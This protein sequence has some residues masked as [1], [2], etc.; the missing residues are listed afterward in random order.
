MKLYEKMDKGVYMIAEMSANHG[1]NLENALKIVEEAKKAGADCV[2]IQTYT[3]DTITIDCDNDYFKIKGGLWDGYSYYDL[4]KQAYTPWEWHEPIKRKCEETGIDFLSTP[5]DMSSVDFLDEL[6]VEAYKIASFELV[7]IPLIEYAAGKGKPMIISCGM[8]GIDEIEEA[9]NACKRNNNEQII[10]LKCCS[11]YPAQFEDMNVAVIEDMRKRFHTYIGLSDHSQGYLAAVV[12]VSLGAKIIEK[13]VCLS[14]EIESA[15][16]EFSMEMKEYSQL[17]EAVRNAS[18]IKGE[19][20][21]ELTKNEKAGLASRRSLF[22]VKDIKKGETF[23]RENV[24][25]I[26]PGYGLKPKYYDMIIGKRAVL[27]YKYGQPISDVE[28]DTL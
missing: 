14:R 17:V 6:G 28:I 15:D 27:E 8:A 18:I 13:H 11:Q 2:K 4:Y 10:L 23:T 16:R 19:A 20:V 21:Y 22:A 25:S 5:F 9:V 1:G 26:R 7:D 12:A 24:R 3:P